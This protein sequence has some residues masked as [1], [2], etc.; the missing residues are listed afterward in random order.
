MVSGNGGVA[1]Q[2]LDG[3]D[4]SVAPTD[5]GGFALIFA[6]TSTRSFTP[7]AAGPDNDGTTS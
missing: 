1:F 5:H 2:P 3:A 4:E 7:Y 6:A